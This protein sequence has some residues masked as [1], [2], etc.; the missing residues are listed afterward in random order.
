[1]GSERL[2]SLKSVYRLMAALREGRGKGYSSLLSF[3]HIGR[4][5]RR[6]NAVIITIFARKPIALI[7]TK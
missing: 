4:R 2:W 1:M 6:T 5:A 3:F 7:T